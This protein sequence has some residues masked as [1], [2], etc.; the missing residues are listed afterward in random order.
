VGSAHGRGLLAR[1][2]RMNDQSIFEKA[3]QNEPD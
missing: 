3:L 2:R 1:S